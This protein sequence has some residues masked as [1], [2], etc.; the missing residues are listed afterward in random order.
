MQAEAEIFHFDRP[1][2]CARTL[3]DGIVR[4]CYAFGFASAYNIAFAF[5]LT[6]TF[7]FAVAFALP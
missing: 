1:L 5:G 2:C 7:A 4:C 3:K 6:L